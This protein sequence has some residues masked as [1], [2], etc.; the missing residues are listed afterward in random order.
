[1]DREDLPDRCLINRELTKDQL[2]AALGS[3]PTGMSHDVELSVP[4]IAR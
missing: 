2:V 1:M 3:L 4:A